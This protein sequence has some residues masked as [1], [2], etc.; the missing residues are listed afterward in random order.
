MFVK[1]IFKVPEKKEN[2]RKTTFSQ[3]QTAIK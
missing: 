3:K 1:V 2:K